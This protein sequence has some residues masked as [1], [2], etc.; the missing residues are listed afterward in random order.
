MGLGKTI[1]ALAVLQFL[2]TE[3]GNY[4]PFLVVAPMSTI[5]QW[6]KE[7]EGWTSMNIVVFQGS[8]KARELIL[9]HEWFFKEKRKSVYKFNVLVTTYE[10]A[11]I[12]APTLKAVPWQYCIID[13]RHRIKNQNSKLFGTL[14]T[15]KVAHKLILTGTPLQNGVKELWALMNYLEPSRFNDCNAFMEEF[16]DLKETSQV[17]KLHEKLSLYLLRRMK[18]TVETSIPKKEGS[19]SQIS[20]IETHLNQSFPSSPISNKEPIL[21]NDSSLSSLSNQFL[22]TFFKSKLRIS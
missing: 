9:E 8:A 6:K 10:V 19:K 18:E 3:L 20:L 4:G 11:M 1:Q 2:F 13:E 12:E 7:L 16:G 21:L 14:C 22:S 15:F 5:A 17:D